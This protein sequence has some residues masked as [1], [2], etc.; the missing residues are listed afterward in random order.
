MKKETIYLG[1]DHAGFELKEYIKLH[2]L[3]SGHTVYDLGARVL[4]KH[5]DYPDFAYR[6]AD[7]VSDNPESFGIL[8]C[9]SAQGMCIAANKHKGIRAVSVN[10]VREAKI[11]RS[12]NNS[13]VLCLA[14][15][16]ISKQKAIAI[17]DAWLTTPFSQHVRHVRRLKKIANMER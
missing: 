9:G 15:W 7:G 12:H 17:I 10:N 1:A 16:Y 4:D 11:T 2:L 14:G 3:K 5:D 13:N 6:V 8:C